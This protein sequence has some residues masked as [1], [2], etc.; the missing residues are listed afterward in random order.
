[1]LVPTT[2]DGGDGNDVL[3]GGSARNALIGGKG[4]DVISGNAGDDRLTRGYTSYDSSVALL[5]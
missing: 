3:V 1:V 2:I 4:S 5:E